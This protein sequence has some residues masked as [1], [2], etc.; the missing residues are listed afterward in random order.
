MRKVK[1][2]VSLLSTQGNQRM[3]YPSAAESGFVFNALEVK[4]SVKKYN[5]GNKAIGT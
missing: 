1:S 4:V 5:T 2:L 3:P